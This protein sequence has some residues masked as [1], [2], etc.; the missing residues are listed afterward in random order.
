MLNAKSMSFLDIFIRLL[1]GVLGVFL[2]RY[3]TIRKEKTDT[4]FDFFREFNSA[5]MVEHRHVAGS[6][7]RKY[8]EASA[9]ELLQL[10]SEKSLSYHIV[11]RFYQRLW[12]SI[13]YNLISTRY[14]KEFFV[15]NFYYWYYVSWENNAVQT[16]WASTDRLKDFA[17]WFESALSQEVHASL[18]EKNI[19]LKRNRI[20][21]VNDEGSEKQDL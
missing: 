5:E 12:M 17:I 10:D 13:K 14:I 21:A 3:L 2:G 16:G 11:M 6:I 1:P 8:P 7:I 15:E 9:E 19:R 4:A 20:D 18:K